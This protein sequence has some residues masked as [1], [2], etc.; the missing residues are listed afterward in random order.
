MAAP[1]VNI[2]KLAD[3]LDQISPWLT[4]QVV[5]NLLGVASPFNGVVGGRVVEWST[6]R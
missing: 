2:S 3:R 1:R 4:R 6:S 5:S